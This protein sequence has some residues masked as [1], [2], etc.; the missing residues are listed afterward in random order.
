MSWLDISKSPV[1]KKE[2]SVEEQT[3][4]FVSY[5]HED[6]AIAKGLVSRFEKAGLRCFI[7][8]QD[9]AAGELWEPRIRKAILDA[10]RIFLLITPRSKNSPWIA[11]EAGAAW[12]L[13]K[14]LIAGLM[15][16]KPIDLIDVIRR[17]QTRS[18]ETQDEIESLINELIPTTIQISRELTGRWIDP[19]DGDTVYFRQ[20]GERVVGFYDYS[21]GDSKVGLYRGTL[22]NSK[23][24]Y[25]WKW[26]KNDLEGNGYMVL[27]E[28]GERLSGKWWFKENPKG[29]E[30]VQYRRTS[31]D[32]PNWVKEQD[33]EDHL[34]FFKT[35]KL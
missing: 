9:I 5:S 25:H 13:E 15:F 26:L 29:T 11:A 33:F 1:S 30:K 24:E 6:S 28:D 16:V 7:A 20:I 19:V 18:I 27:S 8:E 14:E 2:V 10:K 31:G 17:H 4:L 34:V 32:M 12:A 22:K 23:F 3:D 35:G 21:S